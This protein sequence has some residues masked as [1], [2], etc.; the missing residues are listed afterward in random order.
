M[1]AR[2]EKFCELYAA[3]RTATDAAI[4]AGYSARTAYSQGPRLLKNADIQARIQQLQEAAAA[5]GVADLSEILSTFTEILRGGRYS[6]IARLK[7]GEILLKIRML[8][9][10][11]E[12]AAEGEAIEAPESGTV[13]ALPLCCGDPIESA[14]AIILD[15]EV[16]PFSG[17]EHDSVLIYFD[18]KGYLPFENLEIAGEPG[19]EGGANDSPI[20]D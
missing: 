7:A 18:P 3:G 9:Q 17:H 20:F 2:R 4:E 13:I 1:N 11:P 5:A 12:I 19:E 8:Q 16:I 6:P 14:N 15:G 10:E